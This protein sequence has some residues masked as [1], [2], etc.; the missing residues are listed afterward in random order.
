MPEKG[1]ET[2]YIFLTINHNITGLEIL[3]DM[4]LVYVVA[5]RARSQV[6]QSWEAIKHVLV[7]M[8]QIVSVLLYPSRYV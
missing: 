7:R 8:W 2:K 3:G 5:V 6:P 1:A 4:K